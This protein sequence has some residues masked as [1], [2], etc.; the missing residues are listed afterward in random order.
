M[1]VYPTHQNRHFFVVTHCV[2]KNDPGS[3][4]VKKMPPGAQAGW[5]LAKTIGTGKDARLY[6]TYKGKGDSMLT[7]DKIQIENFTY[8]K[9]LVPADMRKPLTSV[10]VTLD[11]N[12]NNGKPVAGQDYLLRINFRQFFGMSDEDQ[13]FKDAVVR[14]TPA[15]AADEKEFYKAMVKS[16][17]FNFS[18]EIG[19]TKTSNPYLTFSAGT[20]DSEDGIY[21][22]EKPQPYTT[23]IQKQERVLFEVFPTT[24]LYGGVD[25]IWAAQ[26]ATTGKYYEDI[27]P[28][29]YTVAEG[30]V[31]PNSELVVSG[32]N[33]NALG[34]GAEIADLE[35]FCMGERGDQYRMNGWPNYIPTQ[36]MVDPSQEYY[37]LELHFAFTDWGVNSYRSEK[38]ITFVSTS[39][40][41]LNGLVALI[42]QVTQAAKSTVIDIPVN[43]PT[44]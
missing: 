16:L 6:F 24:I 27:T 31:T 44:T 34:N 2:S 42:K 36:Y 19:A 17:N 4:N 32:A 11:P 5:I 13:Y 29:K 15:M 37:V 10:K 22:T 18:R 43:W 25:V 12:I 3:D 35:W 9:G 1:A 20:A 26:D 7:T 14:V 39:A 30:V 41:P 8:G 40:A 33:Q 38:D 21:I 23:G 28:Q